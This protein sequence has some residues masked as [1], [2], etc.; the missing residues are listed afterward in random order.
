MKR[1]RFLSTN[2]YNTNLNMTI[3]SN[4]RLRLH[5]ELAIAKE[6][7]IKSTEWSGKHFWFKIKLKKEPT[8]MRWK[9]VRRL[10][11]LSLDN[12]K[13]TCFE[14]RSKRLCMRFV[15]C[16]ALWKKKFARTRGFFDRKIWTI[17]PTQRRNRKDYQ[18]QLMCKLFVVFKCAH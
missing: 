15:W 14:F 7:N 5:W 4:W 1:S 18:F 8:N 16:H 9:K 17:K 11:I 6:D 12:V 3:E 2:L 10:N 13:L